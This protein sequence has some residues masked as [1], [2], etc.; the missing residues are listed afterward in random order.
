MSR[1]IPSR[2]S[3]VARVGRCENKESIVAQQQAEARR[4]FGDVLARCDLSS[5]D[6]RE[7]VAAAAEL[8]AADVH[9][10]AVTEL[11]CLVITPLT[12][13]FEVDALV[14]SA[15]EE[16]GMPVLD[17][18]RTAIRAA[19][20]QARRWRGG[21]LTD[22]QLASW[23]HGAIGH[24]GPAVLQDLVVADDMLDESIHVDLEVIADRVL[25]H[26]D[27]WQ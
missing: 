21:A 26:E 2:S 25:A 8:L 15:R 23:A 18:D 19:Q 3:L 1:P 12:S 13:A 11:A 7:V 17:A 20:A 9:G 22:R 6:G 10:P 4:V 27:P 5:A 14:A 24:D 16:L